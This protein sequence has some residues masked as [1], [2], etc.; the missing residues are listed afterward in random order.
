MS[1]FSWSIWIKILRGL[2]Y[3]RVSPFSLPHMCFNMGFYTFFPVRCTGN[4]RKSIISIVL[5]RVASPPV[6]YLDVNRDISHHTDMIGVW[7][8]QNLHLIAVSTLLQSFPCQPAI[9]SHRQWL[10]KIQLQGIKSTSILSPLSL[11][12]CCWDWKDE[13]SLIRN[14]NH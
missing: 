10:E 6:I 8:I 5:T 13:A 4:G 1:I 12:W 11:H 9:P 3:W 7:K 2:G 14:I